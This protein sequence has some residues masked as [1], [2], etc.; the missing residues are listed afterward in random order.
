MSDNIINLTLPDEVLRISTCVKNDQVSDVFTANLLCKGEDVP[1]YLKCYSIEEGERSLLNE[2]I[3][4]LI[5]NAYMIPQPEQAFIVLAP[6]TKFLHILPS[7]T[8]RFKSI[9]EKKE[10]IPMFATQRLN[11]KDLAFRY[12]HSMES[13]IILL[14]HWR[15]Y[16]QASICD[17]V[18]ANRDRLPRN[19]LYLGNKDFWLI[20]N[21]VLAC[22][23]GVN[24]R[25]NDLKPK[26]NFVN[27]LADLYKHE[28]QADPRKGSAILCTSNN[29]EKNIRTVVSE[30]NYWINQLS[31]KSDTLE[32]QN[33]LSFLETRENIR[34]ELLTKRYGMLT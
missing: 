31:P 7:T 20:D 26:K 16:R 11:G 18:L 23:E 4:Y 14:R 3:G 19:I 28:I 9:F 24:W 17:E 5:C 1:V 27:F 12:H 6:R 32:W 13:V 29:I 34:S 2:V 10:Y 15:Y 33:F 22:D 25:K 30:I 21:G 8:E